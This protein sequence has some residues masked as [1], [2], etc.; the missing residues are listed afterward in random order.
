MRIEFFPCDTITWSNMGWIEGMG[1]KVIED[2]RVEYEGSSV[3]SSIECLE[4]RGD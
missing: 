3:R 1:R 2:D 4:M